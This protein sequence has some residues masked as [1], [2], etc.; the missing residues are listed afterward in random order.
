MKV[1][2][3]FKTGY[4]N[5][6]GRSTVTAIHYENVKRTLIQDDLYIVIFNDDK[7]KSILPIR[8]IVKITESQ[9]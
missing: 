8:N 1:S 2:I 4:S 7:H 3:N 9:E 5:G 6:S